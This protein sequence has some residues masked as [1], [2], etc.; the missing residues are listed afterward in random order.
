M[1]KA[2]FL[3]RDGVLVEEVNYL[4]SPSQ[5]VLIDDNVKE[6]LQKLKDN[7][8]I[9]IVITNQSGIGRGYFTLET[10]DEIHNKINEMVDYSIDYFFFCPH[11]P[12]DNCECRKPNPNMILTASEMFDIDS[13]QSWAIGDKISDTLSGKN[14]GCKTISV[15]TGYGETKYSDFTCSDIN[16][17]IE[18]VCL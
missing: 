2:V 13:S 8:Y 4:S 15:L 16:E 12:E 7:G 14:A 5:L 10:L 1:N 11:L 9:I 18:L 3:D 6:S 17:A